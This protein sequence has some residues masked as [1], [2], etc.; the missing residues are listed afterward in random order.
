MILIGIVAAAVLPKMQGGHG[1]EERSFRDQTVA[2]L[3]FAQKAAIADRRTAC[4]TFDTAGTPHRV[5]FR[6][7]SAHGAADCTAGAALILHDGSSEVA[8]TGGAAFSAAPAAVIFDANGGA[9]AATISVTQLD[10]S[11]DIRVEATTG[12]VH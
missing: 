5:T 11:L 1:F 8:A 10:A 7:S 6:I 9:A 2:A 4:A 3:R 12:Y